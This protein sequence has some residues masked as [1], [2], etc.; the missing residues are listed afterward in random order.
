[1]ET[2][3]NLQKH[4]C[5]V[6]GSCCIVIA[7]VLFVTAMPVFA[8]LPTGTILGVVKDSSG[9]VIPGTLVTVH[10]DETGLSRNVMASADGG[11]RFAALPVGHYMVKFEKVGFKMETQTGLVLDV[12]QEMVVNS[13]L[14][15][16]TTTQEVVV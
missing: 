16:G 13:T 4:S 14:Q 2:K 8:Q 9:A 11:Y 3:D 7:F 15:V 1:M 6:L 10:N 5:A 12:A